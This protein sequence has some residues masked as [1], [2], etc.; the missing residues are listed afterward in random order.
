M[1]LCLTV[2]CG[3]VRVALLFICVFQHLSGTSRLVDFSEGDGRNARK[4]EETWVASK[5]LG[6]SWY[7]HLSILD[8]SKDVCVLSLSVVSNCL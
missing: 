1:T 8:Q 6:S 5:D 2:V 7:F 3:L 4:Q